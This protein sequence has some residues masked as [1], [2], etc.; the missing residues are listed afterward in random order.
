MA[1]QEQPDASTML[2]MIKALEQQLAHVQE[3]L[4]SYVPIRENELQIQTLQATASRIERDVIAMK[5]KQEEIERNARDATEK[6]RAAMAELQFKQ[7]EAA[8]KQRAS[9]AALQI[10]VLIGFA[11]AM[12]AIITSVI[13]GFITHFF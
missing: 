1:P 10:R 9:I 8:D 7:Q 2:Y 3:Q 6:Q 5:S 13:A 4:K 11:T 12:V